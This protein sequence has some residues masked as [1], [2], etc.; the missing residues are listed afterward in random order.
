MYERPHI[1]PVISTQEWFD[2]FYSVFNVNL[3]IIENNVDV[4][5]IHVAQNSLEYPD[6]ILN[7]S[8]AKL[9]VDKSCWT[10]RLSCYID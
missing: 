2:H 8:I 5:E 1:K 9:K 3:H 7:K 6:G 4:P 10:W